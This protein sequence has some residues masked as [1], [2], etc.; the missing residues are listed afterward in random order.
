MDRFSDCIT[1]GLI[2]ALF[3]RQKRPPAR[4]TFERSRVC[5]ERSG[6]KYREHTYECYL[7]DRVL[8]VGLIR[9]M[10]I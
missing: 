6:V 10:F 5:V 1:L 3:E 8:A 9:S 7:R 2:H 4:P